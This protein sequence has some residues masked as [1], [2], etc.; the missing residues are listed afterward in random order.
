MM[1][2]KPVPVS[3]ETYTLPPSARVVVGPFAWW[4]RAMDVALSLAAL[5]VLSPILMA[6][7][8]GVLLTSGRPV[9]FRQRR[10]G[11]AGRPFTLYK[12]RSMVVRAEEMKKDLKA[13]NEASG[14]VFK[15]R[16]DPRVTPF[17]RFIRKWSIDELPQL[18]NVLKGD[19]SLVGPRPLPLDEVP[20]GAGMC[21]V[22][23][24][25]CRLSVRPGI[26]CYWQVYGRSLLTFEQW[27]EMDMRY[28]SEMSFRTDVKILLMTVRAVLTRRGAV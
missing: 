4:K 27:F 21:Q 11:L 25:I 5:I 26:T 19:M 7:A 17:G 12:F 20:C 13:L 14:P 8:V 24:H 10:F 1:P 16:N 18:W 2:E 22:P 23:D 6:T 15:M 3:T 9:L 28:M